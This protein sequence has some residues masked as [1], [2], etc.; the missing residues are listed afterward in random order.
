MV[1]LASCIIHQFTMI[2]ICKIHQVSELL[3]FGLDSKSESRILKICES[4]SGPSS[5]FLGFSTVLL[6]NIGKR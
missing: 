3:E 1:C 2:T 6:R 5:N 4:E